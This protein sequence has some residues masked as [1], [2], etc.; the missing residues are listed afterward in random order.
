[1]IIGNQIIRLKEVDSTNDYLKSFKTSNIA[2]EGLVV[3][4]QNQ[5]KG[6]GQMGNE[7]L[8]EPDK[9]LTFSVLLMPKL[10]INYSFVLSMLTSL[11][12][13]EFLRS[14]GLNSPLIKW[15]NDI[16]YHQKKMAGILIE[17]T[18]KK[19]V[20]SESIIGVGINI[21]QTQFESLN[22]TS[23]G[24]VLNKTIDLEAA[25]LKLLKLFDAT[26]LKFKQQQNFKSIK[27]EY[28]RNIMG[29]NTK[30]NFTDKNGDSFTAKIIDVE[31]NGRLVL[32]T[33]QKEIRK[34]FFKEVEFKI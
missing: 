21:N 25:L 33:N 22:A 24:L 18:I 32:E 26:Y 6:R 13:I 11:V 7:W 15:P 16:Y 34:Y 12:I 28:L 17:N 19:E 29:F 3:V 9:N 23:V 1:L 5:K 4:A 8:A 27:Q 30:L 2:F 20:I 14:I 10:T 31:W